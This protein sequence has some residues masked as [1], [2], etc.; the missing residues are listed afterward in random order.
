MS[1][2][3]QLSYPLSSSDIYAIKEWILELAIQW[4][5]YGADATLLLSASC[6]LLSQQ[7]HHSM[8]Q[9][10]LL[11]LVVLMLILSSASIALN[12]V[13][14]LIQIPSLGNDVDLINS[15]G[16]TV[17]LLQVVAAS[18]IVDRVNYVTGDGIVVWR[19][20]AMYPRNFLVKVILIICMIAS[21]VGTFL[22]AGIG[23]ARVLG[24]SDFSDI[25]GKKT[26]ALMMCLPLLGTNIIATVCIGYKAW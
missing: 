1:Q 18:G 15:E 12:S 5:L 23:A 14:V 7:K 16:F 21:V 20:W 8:S 4:L 25:L 13:F 2:T 19:A 26:S 10:T 11:A 22:D 3:Q 6:I 9:R 24:S 17:R